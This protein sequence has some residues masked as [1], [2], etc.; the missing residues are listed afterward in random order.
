MKFWTSQVCPFSYSALECFQNIMQFTHNSKV[1]NIGWYPNGLPLKLAEMHTTNTG[2]NF[3][4]FSHPRRQ[5]KPQS[6]QPW[7]V[8]PLPPKDPEPWPEP[9]AHGS[10]CHY[11]IWHMEE[12]R[13]ERSQVWKVF[14][15]LGQPLITPDWDSTMTPV[16]WEQLLATPYL[17]PAQ[18]G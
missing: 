11:P 1:V 7:R 13:L 6:T 10:V 5:P 16:T 8:P 14:L 12:S 17:D 4:Y 3:N 2:S 18:L 9:G 15:D